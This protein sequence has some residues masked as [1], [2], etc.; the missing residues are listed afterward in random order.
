MCKKTFSTD[1]ALKKHEGTHSTEASDPDPERPFACADCDFR[2]KSK[3]HLSVHR[4]THGGRTIPCPHCEHRSV[5]QQAFRIHLASHSD[6]KPY[7]CEECTKRFK[8]RSDLFY[9][10]RHHKGEVLRCKEKGC[11]YST[12]QKNLM[13][14]HK[15]IHTGER[16][17]KCD[18]CELSFAERGNLTRHRRMVHLSQ[19]RFK[20]DTCSYSSPRSDLLK[21]HQRN[22]GS[23]LAFNRK[24]VV[25]KKAAGAAKTANSSPAVPASDRNLRSRKAAKRTDFAEAAPRVPK[26]EAPEGAECHVAVPHEPAT[27]VPTVAAKPL[28]AVRPMELD[29]DVESKHHE[30]KAGNAELVAL[31]LSDAHESSSPDLGAT[32]LVEAAAPPDHKPPTTE[33]PSVTD[34]AAVAEESTPIAVKAE[35][36]VTSM[37]P[38]I[39]GGT[40]SSEEFKCTLMTYDDAS[41]QNLAPMDLDQVVGLE[42][43]E[44]MFQT[45]AT[46][47]PE[48]TL[49]SSQEFLFNGH[50]M[51]F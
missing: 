44:A 4:R 20:C 13:R 28:E 51:V 6:E 35:P 10:R 39:K 19:K 46:Q 50:G 15:L 33:P 29:E 40:D 27:E 22:C 47:L 31:L 34:P 18:R 2:A 21:R 3:S 16:P 38:A 24:R 42:F 8:Y 12:P 36:G 45:V 49:K 9:H 41:N 48:G 37:Q 23:P 17:H 11:P 25:T 26:E 14:A 5:T 1:A 30:E 7:A 32:V 43:M